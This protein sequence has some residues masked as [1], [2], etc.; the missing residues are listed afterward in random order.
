MRAPANTARLVTL[1]K[2]GSEGRSIPLGEG[3][4][5]I[6]SQEGDITFPDDPYLENDTIGAV[7]PALVRSVEP[8]GDHLACRFDIS[9]RS[10]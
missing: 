10:A 1:L 5:D 7:K 3:D 2:D 4:A 9:L 8:E 6:G